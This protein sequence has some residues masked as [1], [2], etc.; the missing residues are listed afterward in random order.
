MKIWYSRCILVL[1]VSS[2][3]ISIWDIRHL[4]LCEHIKRSDERGERFVSEIHEQMEVA[5][6][7]L[8]NWVIFTLNKSKICKRTFHSSNESRSTTGFQCERCIQRNCMHVYVLISM[9]ILNGIIM[10]DWKFCLCGRTKSD[11]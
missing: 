1:E 10:K 4:L 2:K 6:E 8:N 7:D 11:S 9:Y 5:G 3:E